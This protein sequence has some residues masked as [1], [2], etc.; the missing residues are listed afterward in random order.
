MEGEIDGWM[1]RIMD[2]WMDGKMVR[3]I[4]EGVGG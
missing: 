3:W 1:C 4:D 2:A